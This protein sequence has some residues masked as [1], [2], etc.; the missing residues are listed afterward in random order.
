MDEKTIRILINTLEK[1]SVSGEDNMNYMMG[2]IR[3]LKSLL[4][5]KNE[6]GIENAEIHQTE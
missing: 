5:H 2:C 3:L 4:I 1:V 6:E